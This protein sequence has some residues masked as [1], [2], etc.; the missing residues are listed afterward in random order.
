MTNKKIFD[1]KDLDWRQSR[2]CV[3]VIHMRCVNRLHCYD[4][5][6]TVSDEHQNLLIPQTRG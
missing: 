3:N 4:D 2:P 6:E 1:R 5:S